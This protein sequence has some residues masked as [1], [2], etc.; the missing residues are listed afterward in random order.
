MSYIAPVAA[1]IGL[2]VAFVLASW[3][4]KADE[5]TDRM[6]EI[7]GYIREGAMAFLKA[8]WKILTYF[9]II[10]AILLGVMAMQNPGESH[11]SIAV[12]FLVIVLSRGKAFDN[13]FW[14]GKS[15][16]FYP[17]LFE[18]VIHARTRNP[19]KL[20]AIYPAFAYCLIYF[21]NFFL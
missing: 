6:K 19:Y 20:D 5:G 4:G 21:F 11:W 10:V 14:H 12:A 8:E 16:G 2:I 17:D 13:L 1:L 15:L 9:G 3:I 7:S 18:S